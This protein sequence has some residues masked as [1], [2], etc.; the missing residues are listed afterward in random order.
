MGSQ[1]SIDH[2]VDAQEEDSEDTIG[3]GPVSGSSGKCADSSL[4]KLPTETLMRIIGFLHFPKVSIAFTCSRMYKIFKKVHPEPISLCNTG[5]CEFIDHLDPFE[6]EKVHLS[7]QNYSPIL[8]VYELK[9]YVYKVVLHLYE[10]RPA[11]PEEGPLFASQAYGRFLRRPYYDERGNRKDLRAKYRTYE[12]Y[13]ACWTDCMPKG[14]SIPYPHNKGRIM[15]ELEMKQ[16][17]DEL[18]D[19]MDD[20]TPEEYHH[21]FV[22]L[23][24]F[25]RVGSST[26][27]NNLIMMSISWKQ[28]GEWRDMIGF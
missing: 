18:L 8:R 14:F 5:V 7:L 15:Y 24:N 22:F 2:H 13:L 25:L 12:L 17:I 21:R 20:A 11:T 28:F 1:A 26:E 23:V 10:R 6:S 4:E 19:S 3:R 9:N 16:A 27:V